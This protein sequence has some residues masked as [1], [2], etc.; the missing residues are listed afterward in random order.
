[1]HAIYHILIYILC[2]FDIFVLF[3]TASAYV[4][5]HIYYESQSGSWLVVIRERSENIGGLGG[6]VAKRCR[7]RRK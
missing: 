1:M 4:I 3:D 5:I 6:V 2:I 7:K